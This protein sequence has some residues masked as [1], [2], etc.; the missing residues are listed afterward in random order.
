M[1]GGSRNV[2]LGGA[3]VA[4]IDGD[5]GKN[6][7]SKKE[8]QPHGF[9]FFLN[10]GNVTSNGFSFSTCEFI[11]SDRDAK[12]RNGK[13]SRND[14]VLTTR[15]TVGNVA[16]FGPEVRCEHIRI[17]SGMVILRP[18][19]TSV[20]P[21][22]L[23]FFLRSKIFS[24]QVKSLT[25]GS[26]Q[27]QLP[28]RDIRQVEMPLPSL[29]RQ[30]EI[31]AILGALDDKIELNR[32]MS[33]TLEEM[34]RALY[35]SWFVDFDPVHARAL[36]QPPAHMGPT[37]AALFPDSFGP[38]GLPKGWLHQKIGDL[39]SVRGGKQ[40]AKDRFADDG[41]FPVFGGAGKMGMTN[42]TNADGFVITVGR[43][44]AYC[45]KFVSH[46]GKAWVNNNASLITPNPETPPEFLFFALQ[47]LDLSSIKKGAA[48]PFISNGDLKE[49][50]TVIPK[51]EIVDAFHDQVEVVQ[52]RIEALQTENQTL[53][54]LRDT[55][56]PRLMSGELRIR[57]AEEQVEEVV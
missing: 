56:L 18:D 55:L 50:S 7:P 54:A 38:D 43:V 33:A 48:Q 31:A 14:S 16:F 21:R 9:C 4:I 36:G 3:E 11:T 10:A 23:A 6:Y 53:A 57:G 32:Q 17:N 45:G 2:Q 24:D 19:T 13:L 1:T 37:T 20:F 51:A 26:A 47:A 29:D 35:R 42:E 22:Y 41:V 49:L 34:A 30:K 15:G 52:L 44:G 25:S 40:L 27:P 8:L 39:C 12:L 5:R 28:V 46:R